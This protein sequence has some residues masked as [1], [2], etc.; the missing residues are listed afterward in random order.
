[1]VSEQY[2]GRTLFPLVEKPPNGTVSSRGPPS[3]PSRRDTSSEGSEHPVVALCLQEV[4]ECFGSVPIGGGNLVIFQPVGSFCCSCCW[5]Y[6][7]SPVLCCC[8]SLAE[9]QQSCQER[10]HRCSLGT[11]RASSIRPFRPGGAGFPG[12][13]AVT[14]PSQSPAENTKVHQSP[15]GPETP[16]DAEGAQ[17]SQGEGRR[18]EESKEIQ[19]DLAA[20]EGVQLRRSRVP[21]KGHFK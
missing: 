21:R 16:E 4:H 1:M 12:S 2:Q 20:S 8:S 7:F 18:E 14:K 6:L 3:C 13:S 17:D 10:A 5:W 19:R 11:G 9:R 15:Q